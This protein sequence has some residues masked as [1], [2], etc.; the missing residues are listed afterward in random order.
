MTAAYT[1]LGKLAGEAKAS[2]QAAKVRQQQMS[3]LTQL[4]N[5]QQM[6]ELEHQWAVEAYNR[7]QEWQL[8]KMQIA[9]RID[10]ERE[11]KQRQQKIEE[12]NAAVKAIDKEMQSGR[13]TQ[14]QAGKFKLMAETRIKTGW[15]PPVSQLFPQSEDAIGQM[16]S[17]ALAGKVPVTTTTDN[18]IQVISPTGQ[19]GTILENEWSTYQAQGFKKV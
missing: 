15:S 2:Q 3:E 4:R 11:E 8:E 5:R 17:Q 9:S 19:T 18:R 6:A 16:I 10:F 12:F 13:I 7:S 1:Q 14:D